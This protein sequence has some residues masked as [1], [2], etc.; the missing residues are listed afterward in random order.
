[1]NRSRVLWVVPLL[2]FL[3][4]CCGC[5][6][7][8]GLL[9]VHSASVEGLWP[10]R[11]QTE[12][13]G[14]ISQAFDVQG[15]ATLNVDVP[16][17][18]LVVRAGG[19]DR[20]VVE[21]VRRA[22]GTGGS[23]ARRNLERIK[24][25][26]VQQGNELQVT[27]SGFDDAGTVSRASRVDLTFTVPAQTA[28]VISDKVGRVSVTGTE[29]DVTIKC[30]VGEV[31]LADV[32]PATRLDVQ[33][34]IASVELSG[35]LVSEADYE[36]SSDVG[37]I[38]VDAPA[39]SEFSINARSDVGNVRSGFVVDGEST[40]EGLVGKE[41]RGMVGAAPGA[42]LYLRSRVGGIAVNPQ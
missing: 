22:W 27:A 2:L 14:T 32:R 13:T 16:V 10:L 8:S 23:D 17:G 31:I 6:L 28:L 11:L 15:P 19:S 26:L 34:R 25:E 38:V 5:G 12:A 41:I 20:I 39:G 24:V 35:P 42:R 36:L 4:L 3:A 37:R 33:T 9:L 21:G 7:V 18:D 1:M 29:G 40:R 30:D